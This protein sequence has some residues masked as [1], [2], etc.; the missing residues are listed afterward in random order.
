LQQTSLVQLST[1]ELQLQ[2]PGTILQHL[3]NP[4][5]GKPMLILPGDQTRQTDL[6][7]PPAPSI[8]NQLT[9]LKIDISLKR[10]LHI[11]EIKVKG[12]TTLYQRRSA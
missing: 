7:K 8:K 10:K 1:P 9:A 4:D 5:T 2:Q 3:E 12:T 6:S 11:N